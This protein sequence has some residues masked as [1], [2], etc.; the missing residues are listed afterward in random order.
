[1][2]LALDGKTACVTGGTR[3]IGFAIAE[4]LLSDGAH[5][6]VTGTKAD[7]SGPQGSDYHAV[8]LSDLDAAQVFADTLSGL[9]VDILI[10]NAGINKISPFADIATEDFTLIYKVNVV[11]PMIL[12]RA[13]LARMRGK[14]WGRIVN[15]SSIFGKVSKEQRGSYSASKFALDGMTAALSAEVAR[16]GILVNC[17]APGFIDTELTRRVLGDEGIRTLVEQVPVRRLGTAKEVAAFIA[18]LSSPENSFI[19]GQNIAIDGGFTRV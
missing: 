15:I 17:V 1:M 7:G 6:I 5:V 16:D 11:A 13:V 3:G 9:G 18:W 12:C 10:N 19:T 14:G 8:D 4:R 2:G